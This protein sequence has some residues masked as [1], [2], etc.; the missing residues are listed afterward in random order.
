MMIQIILMIRVPYFK[1]VVDFIDFLV[2]IF[3]LFWGGI[4]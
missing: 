1:T 3:S 2:F 4:V